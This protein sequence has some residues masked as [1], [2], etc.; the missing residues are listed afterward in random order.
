MSDSL[1][2]TT[3]MAA[4][5][6]SSI[7]QRPIASIQPSRRRTLASS[8]RS[9]AQASQATASLPTGSTTVNSTM[10]RKK[11]GRATSELQSLMRISYAV[12]C[13]KKKKLQ[14]TQTPVHIQRTQQYT[15][16]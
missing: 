13:L 9:Q 6:T 8:T 14:Q 11:I 3:S 7:D 4:T 12:F 15:Y 1:I 2:T 5:K 10:T 16:K